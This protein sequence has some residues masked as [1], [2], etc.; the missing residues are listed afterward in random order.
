MRLHKHLVPIRD[1]KIAEVGQFFH[2]TSRELNMLTAIRSECK[3]LSVCYF[4]IFTSGLSLILRVAHCLTLF[5]HLLHVVSTWVS[6]KLHKFEF[7]WIKML[8]FSF[9]FALNLSTWSPRIKI[10]HPFIGFHVFQQP[11][12][13]QCKPLN[14]GSEGGGGGGGLT[15]RR[16]CSFIR[17]TY[18]LFCPA[19]YR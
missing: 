10:P 15:M 1:F 16:S 8:F 2:N 13:L 6:A 4:D 18:I 3:L 11:S 17:I 12:S 9:S 5:V 14:L 19:I 7:L